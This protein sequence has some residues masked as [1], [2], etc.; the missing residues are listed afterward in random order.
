MSIHRSGPVP[1]YWEYVAKSALVPDNAPPD[2]AVL[3]AGYAGLTWIEIPS[4]QRGISWSLTQLL[5]F[6]DT[7][8]AL[9][10]NVIL[11]QFPRAAGMFGQLPT[12]INEYVVLVDGLQRFAVGTMLLAGLHPEVLAATPNRQGDATH[13][14]PLAQIV[15]AHAA[16]YLHN[17]EQLRQ[18]KRR[19]I[20]D[21]YTALRDEWTAHVVKELDAGNG[22]DLATQVMDALLRRQVAIDIY[23]NFPGAVELMN[24]FLGLNTV[25]VDLGPVDLL[26]S[27]IVERATSSGWPPLQVESMENTFTEIFTRDE[28]P[29]SELL[30]FVNV[31]VEHV[32]DPAKA[33]TVFPSW[34]GGLASNEVDDFLDYVQ[35]CK[36]SADP[37]V[38]EIRRVGSIPFGMVLAH[39]YRRKLDGNGDPSFFSGGTIEHSSLHALLRACYRTLFD[40]RVGRTRRYVNTTLDGTL[41]TLDA[42]ADAM[43]VE[44]LGFGL[45]QQVDSGWLSAALNRIDKKRAPRVFN[46]MLLPPPQPSGGTFAPLPFGRKSTETHVDHLLPES[47]IQANASGQPEA[48]T[49]RNLAPLPANQNRVAKATSCSSKLGTGGIYDVYV[50]TAQNHHPYAA[51]L[52]SNQAQHGAQLD[53]QLYLEPNQSPAVGADRIDHITAALRALL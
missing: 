24:T 52:V 35:A 16:V 12:N 8:S 27:Y 36:N 37:Y 17:D 13:F 50:Q 39:Y 38:S 42:A 4:Y 26:R 45:G 5:E 53:L 34:P 18:H 29:D 6:L 47:M 49:L 14:A 10:G 32:R 9:L 33:A 1:P 44:F 2:Q 31:L 15:G 19:A 3:Q 22:A 25:R 11:G 7:S 23:F 43:S 30:P 21:Q 41:A 40:G 46:A 51:W 48:L 28:K 20:A